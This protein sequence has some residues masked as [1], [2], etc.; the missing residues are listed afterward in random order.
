MVASFDLN[1]ATLK[2]LRLDILPP[3]TR[4]AFLRCVHLPF[5]SSNDWYLAGGT[6]LALQAGHRQSV[7]L[8]FFTSQKTFDEKGAEETL[9]ETKDWETSS[10]A[11]R[12]LYGKF[13]GAKMSLIAYPFFRPAEPFIQLGAVSILTS[14]DIAAM[15]IVAISQ[16]GRRR[17]FLDLYWL[18]QHRLTLLESVERAERQYTVR[19]NRNHLLK[20]LVYFADAETDPSPTIFFDAD[21]PTV[22]NYFLTEVPR[23]AK[24]I[25]GL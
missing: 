4:K 15:K 11:S 8:D 6:A 1:Q 23:L 16:R 19:Q 24:K 18:C 25:L 5:F 12:T 2:Q 3:T 20:S 14:P 22:K 10:L 21:W 13:S 17:D 9:S 7:D